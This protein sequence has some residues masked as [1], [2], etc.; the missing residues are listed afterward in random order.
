[1]STKF[2]TNDGKNTLLQKFAGVFQQQGHSV[3]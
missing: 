1:M 2:F 3:L